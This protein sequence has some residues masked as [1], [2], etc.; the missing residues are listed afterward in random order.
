MKFITPILLGFAAVILLFVVLK[1]RAQNSLTIGDISSISGDFSNDFT[2]LGR[3]VN[4]LAGGSGTGY[5]SSSPTGT[6]TGT[7]ATSGGYLA[8]TTGKVTSCYISPYGK[9]VCKEVNA[10]CE[11]RQPYGRDSLYLRCGDKVTRIY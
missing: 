1:S 2:N 6:G 4:R 9:Q 11:Y 10:G 8:S 3:I 7:G 5:T